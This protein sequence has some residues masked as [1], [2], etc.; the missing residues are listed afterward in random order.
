[1]SSFF[2]REHRWTRI[3]L[4]LC[5]LS[6]VVLYSTYL[7]TGRE[8]WMWDTPARNLPMEN[9]FIAM[10]A[11]NGLFLALAARDPSKFLPLIDFTIVA[12]IV[13][14]CVMLNDALR[15]GLTANL[16]PGGDVIGAF[17]VPTRLILSHPRRF[18]LGGLFGKPA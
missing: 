14:G 4:I 6:Y 1:L 15:L 11:V 13:H 8:G 18:Y 17:V 10:Y 3:V 12:N 16:R 5:A 2:A 9:M 7:W